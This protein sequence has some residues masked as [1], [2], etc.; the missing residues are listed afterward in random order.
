ME[1]TDAKMRAL[2]AMQAELGERKQ[3][4]VDA[5]IAELDVQSDAEA[6]KERQKL[7]DQ[8]HTS[9]QPPSCLS[10][11]PL[12]TLSPN[13]TNSILEQASSMSVLSGLIIWV[14]C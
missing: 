10:R 5:A 14:S 3:E 2:L 6:R 1:E 8:K 12:Q 4:E 11:S 13:R 7:N 9:Y